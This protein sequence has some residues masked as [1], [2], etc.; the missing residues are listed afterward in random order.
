MTHEGECLPQSG[1]DEL[2]V[3]AVEFVTAVRK[4]ATIDGTVKQAIGIGKGT[5][6]TT[7]PKKQST[8]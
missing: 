1:V 8:E 5:I 2:K 6:W 7:Y 4:S 3:V